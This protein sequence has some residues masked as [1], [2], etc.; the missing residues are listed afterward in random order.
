MSKPAKLTGS[1]PWAADLCDVPFDLPRQCCLACWFPW[2][3]AA[4][5]R[6][7]LLGPSGDYVPCEGIL[8][9]TAPQSRACLF[10]EVLLCLDVAITGNRRMLQKRDGLI[11]GRFDSVC[12]MRPPG[13][14]PVC[15]SNQGRGDVG[16]CMICLDCVVISV[17]CCGYYTTLLCRLAQQQQQ[18]DSKPQLLPGAP[19]AQ[20]MI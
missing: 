15:R 5:Q 16:D 19:A 9:C 2:C 1:N 8:C 6:L 7:Q 10:F 17:G 20:Q 3:V 11:S 12:C 4:R 13:S 18:V 14:D